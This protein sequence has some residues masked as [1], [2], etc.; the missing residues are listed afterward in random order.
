MTFVQEFGSALQL[1]VTWD[2]S[3]QHV[4]LQPRDRRTFLVAPGPHVCHLRTGLGL[5]NDTVADVPLLVREDAPDRLLVRAHVQLAGVQLSVRVWRGSA[6]VLQD[7]FAPG[8][9][10]PIRP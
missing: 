5:S 9:H 10:E 1:H 8:A 2:E 6:L 3:P 7:T 4:T